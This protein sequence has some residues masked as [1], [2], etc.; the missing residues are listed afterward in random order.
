MSEGGFPV[1]RIKFRLLRVPAC[2]G[3]SLTVNR[4]A[5]HWT[6]GTPVS[7]YHLPR[8][9]QL[10]TSV[11]FLTPVHSKESLNL[12]AITR[13]SSPALLAVLTPPRLH[14]SAQVLL[15]SF[16]NTA[17]KTLLKMSAQ[18]SQF[19][20]EKKAYQEQVCP[21]ASQSPFDAHADHCPAGYRR[22]IP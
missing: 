6:R 10:C 12:V 16:S 19:E 9:W 2:H 1:L 8:G 15:D 7:I 14:S 22:H 21:P 11:P 13:H 17:G 18:L 4:Q 3:S 20:E 5:T